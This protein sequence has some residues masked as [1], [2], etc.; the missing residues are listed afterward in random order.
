[1]RRRRLKGIGSEAGQHTSAYVSIRQHTSSYAGQHTSAYVIL[2]QH[3]SAYEAGKHTSAY[4]SIRV[5]Y[6]GV[7][8]EVA[9][10][11]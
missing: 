9:D 10:A 5:R 3:T 1:M 6:G 11:C 2:R 7:G 4:V 8:S